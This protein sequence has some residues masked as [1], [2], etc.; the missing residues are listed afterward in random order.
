M[1]K[2]IAEKI[3][4]E[5]ESEGRVTTLSREQTN[6]LDDKLATEFA[7]VKEDFRGKHLRSRAYIAKVEQT[8]TLKN[9]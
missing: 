8:S 7:K 5:M 3:I 6:A 4:E 1:F 2:S 9:W